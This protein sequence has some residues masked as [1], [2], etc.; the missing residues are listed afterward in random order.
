MAIG[1]G[2]IAKGYA[3]DRAA[4]ILRSAGFEHF[5]LYGGGQ[6]QVQ[7]LRGAGRGW[8]V[9]I[10]HPRQD[11][12]YIGFLEVSAGSISTSGDY[13]HAFIAN[14]RRWHHILNPRTG[15]PIDHTMS[16]T[17]HTTRGL[18]ADA[19]STAA[20]VLGPEAALEMLARVPFQPQAVIIGGDFRL[21][22]TEEAHDYLRMRTNV[23][24]GILAH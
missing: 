15:Y 12:D 14:G 24:E 13:E 2:G 17:L 8:R 20:F 21:Y 6:V 7:G 5:M 18:Y 16:V 10:Q 19:L 11:D 23:H 4:E 9:G 3:L 22:V 1:T